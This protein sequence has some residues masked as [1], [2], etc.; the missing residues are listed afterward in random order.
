MTL[1]DWL[2]VLSLG[3]SAYGLMRWSWT[4]YGPP[5]R[6]A[7]VAEGPQS[8]KPK[9]PTQGFKARSRR[10]NVQNAVNAG[11]EHSKAVQPVLNVQPVEPVATQI[12]PAPAATAVAEECLTLTPREL[13]QLA[14][15]LHERASGATVEEA[16]G[17]AFG[18]KKGASAGYVRA[19]ALWDAATVPPGAAP[20]GTY[21]PAPQ[22][23]KRRRVAVGQR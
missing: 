12:A 10:S 9:R 6:P 3:F 14:E 23:R 4:H 18:V 5:S 16:L 8:V 15:A 7:R 17:R 19:K 22:P 2:I 1:S 13:V 21:Q 11:S 20:A